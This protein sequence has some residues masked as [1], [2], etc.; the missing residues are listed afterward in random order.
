MKKRIWSLV[1]AVLAV[2]SLAAGCGKSGNS[3]TISDPQSYEGVH[4]VKIENTSDYIFRNGK[5]DYVVLYPE[6][7]SETIQNAV[8]ELR[9]FLAGA[10]GGSIEAVTEAGGRPV[11]SVGETSSLK[12]EIPDYAEKEL[13][14]NGYIIRTQG[15]NVYIVGG[16]DTGTANGVYDFL[17]YTIGFRVYAADEVKYEKGDVSLKNFDVTDVPDIDYR[18]GDVTSKIDGDEQYRKRLRYNCNDDVFMYAKGSLY[19]NDFVYLDPKVYSGEQYKKWY[20]ESNGS[21]DYLQLCYTAHGDNAQLSAMLDIVS[22]IMVETAKTSQ[23]NTITFMQQDRNTWCDCKTCSASKEKYGTN[24]AVVIQFLNKLSDLLKKKLAAAGIEREIDI[25]F[26]AYQ[27]T[28]KAPAVRGEDGKYAPIDESVRC[29]DNVFVFFAPIYA[30]FNESILSVNN[31]NVAE[32]LEAWNSVSSKTWVWLYQTNFSHYL[33]PYNSLPTMADRYRFLASQRAAF[34]FDQNQWD[35]NVKTAFHR[36]KAWM[37]AELSWNVNADYNALLD[38]Y[39]SG[40]FYE[41]AEPMRKLFDSVTLHMENLARTTDMDGNIY[42]GI[43]QYTL[44]PKSLLDGWLDL[45]DQAEKAVEKYSTTQ[46]DLYKKLTDRIGIEGM[47]VRYMILDLY[48]GRFNET[49]LRE[50]Q[51]QFMNDCYK[52]GIDKVAEITDIST[53]FVQWGII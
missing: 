23:T 50:K 39:F 41:A 6:D 29:R 47:S 48:A 38:E 31:K 36:L 1:L 51:T 25:C 13:K 52:Y 37:G 30:Y 40:Y 28:E 32:T 45:I 53:V 34:L 15:K 12:Q 33:Y 7:A 22:D 20:S 16:S 35:Q 43:N 44:F 19:H 17:K 3:I 27:Q 8:A 9:L 24:S 5:T 21:T 2:F 10:S 18:V 42:Y 14:N 49:E 46:P 4:E 11:L 26:F